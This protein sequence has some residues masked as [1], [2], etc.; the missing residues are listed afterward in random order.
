VPTDPEFRMIVEDVF[1]IRGRGTVV[2]GRIESG[3]LRVGDA[4]GLQR[5]SA[6]LATKVTGIE[7]FRKQLEQAK[8][9]DSVGVLL[10]GVDKTGV[11]RGDVLVAPGAIPGLG[12][13]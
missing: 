11:Q 10:H 9:G 3:T 6:T 2:T 7:M 13:R 12:F 4:V 8:A 5:D 1:S